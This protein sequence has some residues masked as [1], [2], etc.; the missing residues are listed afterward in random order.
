MCPS[1]GFSL[2]EP[3]PNV[4]SFNSPYGACNKCNGLG[5]V[6]EVDINKIIPDSKLSVKK[7]GIAPLGKYQENW[8]FKQVEVILIMLAIIYP[9]R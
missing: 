6:T 1:S 5:E 9:H 3:E 2:P 4:F 8:I 7:G